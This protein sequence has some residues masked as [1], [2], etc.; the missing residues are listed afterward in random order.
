MTATG[1]ILTR[2]FTSRA[3]IPIAGATV[4]F[5]RQE[6]GG[7][8]A[9]LALR[10]TDGNG[11]TAP[12]QLATP[13]LAA[14]ESPGTDTPFAV[15]DIWAEAPGYELLAVEDVQVFPG[16]QTLQELRLIPLPEQSAAL[17]PEAPVLIPPQTL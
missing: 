9:L 4:V 16:T 7:V 17:T 14:S 11:I 12:V 3:Q 15:C 8:R 1:T 10:V 13:D 5:T 2:V 6:P